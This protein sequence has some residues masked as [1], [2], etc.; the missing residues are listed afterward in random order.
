MSQK[1]EVIK[2]KPTGKEIEVPREVV[3]QAYALTGKP[4]DEIIRKTFKESKD[5]RFQFS[6]HQEIK[7]QELLNIPDDVGTITIKGKGETYELKTILVSKKYKMDLSFVSEDAIKAV[8]ENIGKLMMFVNLIF[9]MYKN[10]HKKMVQL[11]V[12][13]P[14]I[15]E[16]LKMYVGHN[17]T[18]YL[19]SEIERRIGFIVR[20]K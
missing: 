16:D 11:R 6:T 12:S 8:K 20:K 3:N 13:K 4:L 1:E 2:Q 18:M 10:T 7:V 17:E 19:D 14:K 9:S 5:E 15:W